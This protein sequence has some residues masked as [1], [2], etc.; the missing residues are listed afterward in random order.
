MDKIQL[1]TNRPG[2]QL[3]NYK[4]GD[5]SIYMKRDD[6]LDFA[7]GGNKVRLFEYIAA[8]AVKQGAEKIITFGSIHSNHI[9]VAAA[10]AYKLGIACDLILLYEDEKE[11]GINTPN[12]RLVKYCKGVHVVYCST[13]EAHDFID[14]YQQEQELKG[15]KYYW[16]PGGGH[17][18][19]AAQGYVDAAAE[20]LDQMKG[21]QIDAIFLPCGTGTTQAGV[22]AGIGGR[23]PVYGVTVA[24]T[25]ERCRDEIAALLREM[26]N[27]EIKDGDI[28]VLRSGIRYGGSSEELDEMISGLVQSDGIFLD[29]V[30]NA[31][32]FL[33]MTRYI[34]A[35]PEIKTAVYI[36]TGG[37]PNLF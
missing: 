1:F 7:F 25:V 35:H 29:P 24:R 20:I 36:N 12:L 14:H 8:D 21:R 6:L 31:K 15:C 28:H 4:V 26:G 16:I 17:T 3:L 13:E 18:A 27:T 9:R 30:Y 37:S 34:G 5:T 33:E 22:L 2:T 10:T 11:N 19:L 32:S 23:V